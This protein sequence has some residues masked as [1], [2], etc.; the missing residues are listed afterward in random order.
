M[1][2]AFLFVTTRSWI[3]R[4]VWRA[5]QLKNPRYLVSALFAIAYFGFIFFRPGGPGRRADMMGRI[6]EDVLS[7]LPLVFMLLAW[8][9]PGRAA[10]EFSEGEQQFLFSGP[11]SRAQILLYKL[12]RAQPQVLLTVGILSLFRFPN[13]YG[14]GLWLVANTLNIYMTFVALARPRLRSAGFHPLVQ[15]LLGAAI[16]GVLTWVFWTDF[17]GG[18]G[19]DLPASRVILFIPSLFAKALIGASAPLYW[20]P[21]AAI[22][23]VAFFAA[24]KLRV[25]FEELATNASQATAA[26][27]TKMQSRGA[28]TTVSVRR[29]PPL[30]RLRDDAGPE[31]AIL[32]KNL[33]ASMRI[34]SPWLL[35]IGV[36]FGALLVQSFV[37][38]SEA[39]L[40]TISI[41]AI[42]GCVMFPL[43]GAAI[44]Q[45]DFRLDVTRLDLLKSWP[46]RG[47]RLVMGELAAP[48]AIVSVVEIG[49]LIVTGIILTNATGSKFGEIASPVTFLVA[50]LFA[51]PV[52]AAQLVLRNAVPLYFPAWILRS[53]EDQRGLVMSGQ[54]LLGLFLNLVF[55]GLVLAPAGLLAALGFFVA[56]RFAVGAPLYAM[57]V[58]PAV[59]LL[60]AEVWLGVK[61]LAAQFDNIEVSTE[62]VTQ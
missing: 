48:L 27:R 16:G 20:L 45:Q 51:I 25:P 50:L 53:K 59:A 32:W 3:N 44:F 47:D 40:T 26:L 13:G 55:L 52:C 57:A 31:L 11:L 56:S 36:L 5:K 10:L 24:A 9:S 61:L 46:V 23:L 12:L 7:L 30:F 62:T 49:M 28:G 14:V 21:V 58:T 15:G 34:A 41:M 17:K 35:L 60:S 43:I 19:L 6:P 38:T 18:G 39:A 2:R 8:L 42:A 1:I 37:M 33:I 29:F 4:L 22:G 54:R